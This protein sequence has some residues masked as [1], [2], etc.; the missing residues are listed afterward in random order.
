MLAMIRNSITE[1]S[2]AQSITPEIEFELQQTRRHIHENPELSFQ[3]F[4]TSAFIQQRL[5]DLNIPFRVVAGTGVVGTVGSG[6]RCVA[7][8]ADMDALPILEETGLQFCSSNH[9]V[10][11]A[12]GH[13]MHTAM[14]LGAARLLKERER[15][16]EGTVV[17]LFQPGEEKNP[18]GATLMIADGALT[19]PTPQVV[20]GQHVDPE[21]TIGTVS[22]VSGPMMASADELT[23]SIRGQGAHAAQPH[24]GKDPVFTASGLVHHLQD[25][26]SRMRNPLH[27]CVLTITSIHGG[28]AFNVIPELVTM[29]G[30]LRCFDQE[31]REEAWKLL[32]KH[33]HDYCA[34]HGCDGLV[35]IGKGYPS[36]VNDPDTTS[37]ARS[38]AATVV[39]EDCVQTFEPKMWAEDFA[40]YAQQIPGCFW[41]L[42]VRHPEVAEMHGLHHP[43]FTPHE[44]ALPLGAR[45]LAATAINYL[46]LKT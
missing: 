42:G 25:V 29:M 19:N 45:L 2:S 11:H 15:D 1:L 8:R 4:Q 17:L 14:L 28:S 35:E 9:G 3:E 22:F 27:A 33:T 38:V 34:L 18:G 36:L 24:K 6:D 7:L 40:Y 39:G 46:A 44:A 30:T 12:C 23:W 26:F 32:E 31:W 21:A 16:L 10:M 43:K 20:F 13:D 5:T 41:M 37:F